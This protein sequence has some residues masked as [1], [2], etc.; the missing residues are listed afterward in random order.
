[1]KKFTKILCGVLGLGFLLAGCATVGNIKNDYK[2]V[3]FNGN[4]AVMVDGH[5]YYGNSIADISTFNK[6]SDYN[7]AAKLSYLARLNSNVELGSKNEKYS[8]KKVE[9]VTEQVVG[10]SKDFMCVVGNYIYYATPNREEIKTDGEVSHKY[11]YTT[12]YRTKL[13]GDNK[14]KIYTTKGEVSQIEVL[15]SGNKYY[16]M[17]FAGSTLTK[18]EVGNNTSV[19]E[20]ANDVLSVAMPKTYQKDKVGSTLDFNGTIYF[21]TA[22]K[23][24]NYE[25]AT[26]TVV[27]RLA[28]DSNETEEIYTT[29]DAISFVGREKDDVFYTLNGE[30][31]KL[32]ASANAKNMFN[33]STIKK[34]FYTSAISEIS[35]VAGESWEFGYLFKSSSTLIYK[36]NDNTAKVVKFVDSAD[37]AISDYN[38]LFMTGTAMYISTTT[39]IY[40]ADIALIDEEG[41]V[42]CTT[43]TTMEGIYDGSYYA[44]DGTYVYFY[45]QLQN[46]EVEGSEE[47]TKIT[48]TDAHYYLYRTRANANPNAPSQTTYQLLSLT[49]TSERHS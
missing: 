25:N 10:H 7:N 31:I 9:K 33:D 5:L 4:S 3:I 1:M 44:Y 37:T 13:N 11:T 32:D 6:D 47:E 15:K 28:L 49:E 27:S 14:S 36:S 43:L 29:L 12:L 46:E 26:G 16:I 18:I 48:D 22:R 39:S 19:E 23:N 2:E 45:A 30:T 21:T 42:D 24:E 20:I 40:K 41:N 17:I 34:R 8:P 35:L 38:I